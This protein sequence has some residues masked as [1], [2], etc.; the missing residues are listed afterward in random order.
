VDDH[1]QTT[2]K[3]LS[4]P[5]LET[6]IDI[7]LVNQPALP[8]VEAYRDVFSRLSRV[9][10]DYGV[11]EKAPM[12]AMIP[13]AF[14]W[15]DLGSWP[16]LARIYDKDQSSNVVVGDRPYLLD[17]S[18]SLFFGFQ[19]SKRVVA[20][21]LRDVVAVDAGDVLLLTSKGHSLQLK[22]L[23]QL[24][25]ETG[26]ESLVETAATASVSVPG[27]VSA[28]VL[29]TESHPLKPE[30][31]YVA[32][33]WGYEIWWART[34]KYVGKVLFVRKD[35]TLSLQYHERKQETML[36][37]SGRGRLSVNN[38]EMESEPGMSVTISPK[39]VHLL[40]AET[41]LTVVEVSTPRWTM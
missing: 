1:G 15:D 22:Q 28:G 25:R 18:D 7:M 30:G 23:L 3:W 34:E 19:Q 24:L 12:M 38:Q 8:S 36:C 35:E 33:P 9:S 32:K 2:H 27:A 4:P 16:A 26:A 31:E 21:G 17:T 41:D 39:A 37:L 6:L 10:V 20:F 40:E 5:S 11:M 29:G 14:G 13:G